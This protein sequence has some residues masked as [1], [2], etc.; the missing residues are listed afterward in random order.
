MAS[1]IWAILCMFIKRS[2]WKIVIAK[3]FR[4]EAT[5]WATSSSKNN[6]NFVWNDRG[7]IDDIKGPDLH[8]KIEGSTKRCPRRNLG[9]NIFNSKKKHTYIIWN[10]YTVRKK[11]CKRTV[12][13]KNAERWLGSGRGSGRIPS[14]M[15]GG[16]GRGPAGN[17]KQ[18]TR[19]TGRPQGGCKMVVNSSG[20]QHWSIM[21]G[22]SDCIRKDHPNQTRVQTTQSKPQM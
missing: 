13:L 17:R 11:T 18:K 15:M 10:K 9:H 19:K 14:W 8:S 1:L 5:K 7:K 6:S 16:A 4:L 12:S 22:E 3:H 2:W 20:G 21:K